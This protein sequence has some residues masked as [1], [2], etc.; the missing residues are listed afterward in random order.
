MDSNETKVQN[1]SPIQF[2]LK[3]NTK[4]EYI[5]SISDEKEITLKI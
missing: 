5:L 3:I 2:D 4:D 1:P